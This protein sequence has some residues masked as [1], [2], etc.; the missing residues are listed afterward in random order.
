[1]KLGLLVSLFGV[2]EIRTPGARVCSGFVKL[3]LLVGL[4]GVGEIRTPGVCLGFGGN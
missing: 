2:W 4:F 3:G 1:M